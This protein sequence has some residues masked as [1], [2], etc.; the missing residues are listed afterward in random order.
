MWERSDHRPASHAGGH[1]FKSSTV[2][3]RCPA[4]RSVPLL[5]VCH[6]PAMPPLL[7]N[8]E[9]RA[10]GAMVST[11]D[12]LAST[13]ARD[14]LRTGGNAVDAA[15]AANAV[16]TVTA[17]HFCGLG[18]DLFALVHHVGGPPDCLNASG[19][20]GSGADA[21]RLL[22]E[23]HRSMPH[24]GD[25]R[26]VP[27]P[28]VVDGWVELHGRHGSVPL[29]DL[30]E[31]A[32]GLATDGFPASPLLVPMAQ[33][34][35]G[36]PGAGDFD[37]LARAGQQVRRPGVARVLRALAEGGREAVYRGEFGDELLT[38]GAGEYTV[39]DLERPQADWVQPLGARTWGHDVWTAPPN[40]Q[41]YLTLAATLIAEGLELPSEA[42]PLRAHLLIEAARQAGYDRPQVLHEGADGEALLESGRL[43]RRRAAIDPDR[44]ARLG[45]RWTDGD[46]MYLCVVDGDG[47]AVSLIQS[48][49]DGFGSH[50]TLPG[51]GIF[52]HNRGIGFSTAEG[53]PARYGAGIRPPHTLSP[54]LVTRPDGSLRAVLGT[55]GGDAQPQIVLQMLVRLLHDGSS[56]GHV[57][58]GGRWVL[59]GG[60][61]GF[62][63]WDAPDAVEVLVEDHAPDGWSGGLVARGHVARVA[64]SNYG[65]AHCIEVT[66]DGLV[67][68]ADPRAVIGAA[69]GD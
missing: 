21:N 49:A 27:V 38:V 25:V 66:G 22:A 26:S 41:G 6:A 9:V 42:D 16:L 11:V 3:H 56:P 13:T 46:T 58:G 50:V 48:N 32:V 63:T 30:L 1:W 19:R 65:H 34:V 51:L 60:V 64:E 36:L 53:H 43:D 15:I 67:G 12:L 4:V 8:M 5:A 28:G 20:A 57:V 54:A 40:S 45:D 23:G 7:E 24:R 37:D 17:Q 52:L 10:S 47:M 31:R 35:R 59:R 39:E 44:A 14:V 61:N 68:T 33:A 55:M 69:L 62:S 18:G 29:A 2:H